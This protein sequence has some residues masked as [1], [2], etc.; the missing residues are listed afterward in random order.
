MVNWDFYAI[1]NNWICF[2]IISQTIENHYNGSDRVYFFPPYWF[3]RTNFCGGF[4]NDVIPSDSVWP[5]WGKRVHKK[6][7]LAGL[8]HEWRLS[9]LVRKAHPFHVRASGRPG[10]AYPWKP[11]P[12]FA[13]AGEVPCADVTVA[14]NVFCM[15]AAWLWLYLVWVLTIVNIAPLS[16]WGWNGI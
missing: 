5:S 15:V 9:S 12:P 11:H 8:Q 4:A 13:G 16:G 1:K 6:S 7:S 3:I 2:S 14:G 10:P